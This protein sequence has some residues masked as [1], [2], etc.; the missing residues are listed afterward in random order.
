M[1]HVNP[2]LIDLKHE[3]KQKATA[4]TAE[5]KQKPANER[6]KFIEGHRDETWG[7][8]DLLKALQKPVGNKCW[9][10]EVSLAG[11]DPNVDHFRP[12][13]Q[14]REV[15]DNLQNSKTTSTGYWWL[16]FEWRNFRL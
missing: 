12:K 7:D 13:G 15:D 9:Y 3:W 14:V 6:A 4:L 2:D 16:A 11:Q 8:K 5:L 1:I 10:S